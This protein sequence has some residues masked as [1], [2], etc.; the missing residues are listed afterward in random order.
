MIKLLE[1]WQGIRP[2]SQNLIICSIYVNT[3]VT[4][5]PAYVHR[6]ASQNWMENLAFGCS[7]SQ[8]SSHHFV[9][10]SVLT[11]NVVSQ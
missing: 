3:M 11:H 5:S 10:R 4:H 2:D 8:V 7:V 6:P 1:T 9:P